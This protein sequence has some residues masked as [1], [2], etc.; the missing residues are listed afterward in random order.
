MSPPLVL[1]IGAAVDDASG[2]RGGVALEEGIASDVAAGNIWGASTSAALSIETFEGLPARLA[3]RE[4]PALGRAF[5]AGVEPSLR[6]FEPESSSCITAFRFDMLCTG[7]AAVPNVWHDSHTSVDARDI[8]AA[9]SRIRR[10]KPGK[11]ARATRFALL[12]CTL[13]RHT[14]A[15]EFLVIIRSSQPPK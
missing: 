7:F 12:L 6:R 15:C 1:S 13:R 8:N 5:S 14:W 9:P 11:Q 2:C 10:R 3:V 4:F